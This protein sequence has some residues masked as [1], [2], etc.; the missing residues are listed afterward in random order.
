MCEWM[1]TVSHFFQNKDIL[2]LG[3]GVGACGF[4]AAHLGCRSIVLSDFYFPL[5]ESLA[6][7]AVRVA[8]H[9]CDVAINIKRL[10]WNDDYVRWVCVIEHQREFCELKRSLLHKDRI[11]EDS[12]ERKHHAS[13]HSSVPR[14]DPASSNISAISDGENFDMLIAT[15][16]LYENV[17]ADLLVAVLSIRLRKSAMGLMILPVRDITALQ[18]MLILLIHAGMQLSVCSVEFGFNNRDWWNIV[19]DEAHGPVLHSVSVGIENLLR[20]P[21]MLASSNQGIAG[22]FLCVRAPC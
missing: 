3:S 6:N 8:G 14:F 4:M 17:Q 13:T 10:D 22:I 15:D 18:R 9:C 16:V 2:E 12:H 20:F 5:L 11:Q 7:S 1:M 21:E 19:Q